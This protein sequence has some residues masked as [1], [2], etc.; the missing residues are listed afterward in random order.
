M[1]KII[2]VNRYF[3]PDHSATSQLLSDLAFD[4]AR[5]GIKVNI[6]T[7]RQ[8]YDDPKTSLPRA[9]IVNYVSIK[10]IWTTRFGRSRLWGRALDYL[11][12]YFSAGFSLW[13]LVNQNDVVIAETD[14]PLISV[15]AALVTKFR[16]ANLVNWVQDM[17]PEVAAALNIRGMNGPAFN[18]MRYLRNKSLR[19]AVMNVVLGNLM[20][21][22]L[23]NQGISCQ[24]IKIIPNWADEQELIPIPAESNPL[25]RSWGLGDRFVA[26]YSGNLGRAHEFET[27]LSSAAMLNDDPSIVFLIIGGGVQLSRLKSEVTRRHLRNFVFKPYQPRE[28][29][30]QSLSVADVHLI[31][32]KPELE[33]LIVPSK[34]YGIAAVGLPTIFIGKESGEIASILSHGNCGLTVA[35]GDSV[36]LAEKLQSLC[37]DKALGLRMGTNARRIFEERFSR[38]QST[39]AW[40]EL[41]ES[42]SQGITGQE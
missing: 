12:F 30:A 34:F 9:E 21:K 27:I 14:P 4:L 13:N 22:R 26:G 18:F 25:R 17:F 24:K 6:I 10:R 11:S 32:L 29:L 31:S 15:V 20:A 8:L 28:R 35:A 1:H 38:R 39:A 16:S 33:G 7:G 41:L 23:E 3:Y 5:D 19:T 40:R 42:C 37:H 2:F 36:S